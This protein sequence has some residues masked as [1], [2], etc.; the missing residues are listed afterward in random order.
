[1]ITDNKIALLQIMACS[2]QSRVMRSSGRAPMVAPC[3]PMR[4]QTH[5]NYSDESML[6][7][8]E[9]VTRGEVSIQ[10]ASEVHGV[11]IGQP[12]RIGYQAKLA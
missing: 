12:C 8:Y 2:L 4:P 7:A 3:P 5:H 6:K 9:A 10:R 1:M 11:P